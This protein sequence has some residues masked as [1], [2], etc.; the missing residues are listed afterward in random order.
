MSKGN[1]ALWGGAFDKDMSKSILAFNSAENIKLDEK[2]I[3][4]DIIG[5]LAHVKMLGEQG[6]LKKEEE[7]EIT[8]TLFKIKQDCESGK[9]KLDPALEDVHMNI[10]TAATKIT[11]HAKKMH[12]ARS[13][14]D[15]VLL[16]MRLYMRD[17]CLTAIESLSNLQKSFISLSKKDGLAVGY[18]HTRVAQP[19][20]VS[21]WCDAY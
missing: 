9:F 10:E 16:D 4:Y 17:E 7:K 19:L 20:T 12:T 18:T 2:L 11:N 13:R 8:N 1:T 21:Y 14:N 3:L 5:S 15:Q 6:I